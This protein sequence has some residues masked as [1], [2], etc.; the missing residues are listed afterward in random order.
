MI[1]KER[2]DQVEVGLTCMSDT[3]PFE[4]AELIAAAREAHRLREGL[5]TYI[6]Y[7]R[8]PSEHGFSDSIWKPSAAADL[9]ALLD[10]KEGA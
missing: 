3:N 4:V 1:S 9:Q 7:L 2:L 5:A 6:E 10:G 8:L